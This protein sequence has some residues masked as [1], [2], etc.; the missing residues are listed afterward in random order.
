MLQRSTRSNTSYVNGERSH[1]RQLLMDITPRRTGTLRIPA[2]ELGA[3][4]TAPIEV[5][6]SDPVPIDPDAAQVLFNAELDRDQVYVQGQVI[7]TVRLQ[8][9]INLDNR[10]ISELEL[11]GT[12]VVPLEQQSFQR[13]VGGRPWL[14]HEV[15]YA[16]FPEQS[17]RLSIP[18][19]TFLSLIHI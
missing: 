2:F 18:S 10:S 12:F 6:V 7:L 1:N 9:A 3:A 17:G 19:L 5:R 15:R 13:N 8:Q 4:R 16:I 11:P 14:V